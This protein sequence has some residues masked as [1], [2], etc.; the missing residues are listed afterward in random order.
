MNNYLLVQSIYSYNFAIVMKHLILILFAV[1]LYTGA[2]AHK[3]DS[4]ATKI[5]DSQ[6]C[7]VHKI[8]AGDGMYLISKKYGVTVDEIVALNPGS[9][10]VIKIDEFLL[11]PTG[12][13][14]GKPKTAV[15][16]KPKEVEKPDVQQKETVTKVEEVREMPKTVKPD[17]VKKNVATKYATYHTVTKGET[18]Y[19]LSRKYKTSVA[20]IKKMNNLQ[21]DELA[22]GATLIVVGGKPKAAMQEKPVVPTEVKEVKDVVRQNVQEKK[23]E[24][25]GYVTPVESKETNSSSGYVVRVEKLVE[26]N[27]EKIE[28][29]GSLS[30]GAQKIPE[31][32]NYALHFEAPVGTVIMVTNPEN[33]NT[34]FV[35]VVG[36]FMKGEN[37]S[38][39]IKLSNISAAKIGVKPKS[40]ILLS[41]AR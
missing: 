20:D 35:K 27:I 31:D 9:E 23:Y 17:P 34:V 1:C 25:I 16:S 33:K 6:K 8:K 7:I 18:L 40:K 36:N 28:E 4:V 30:I 13:F 15:V 38:E 3:T 26:Y 37:S 11:I 10:K 21:I 2:L 14:I 39:I 22:E 29:E 19:A 24:D 41:Y 12:V 5:V 32:K